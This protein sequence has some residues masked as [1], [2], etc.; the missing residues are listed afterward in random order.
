MKIKYFLVL[1]ALVLFVSACSISQF[2]KLDLDNSYYQLTFGKNV[3]LK[4]KQQATS[5]FTKNQ[6]SPSTQN[7][8]IEI[9]NYLT[10]R[11]D[12]YAG[13]ALRALETEM[14]ISM[15]IKVNKNSKFISKT[16]MSTK[17]FSS[18][19][20][21]PLAEKEMLKFVEEQLIND[22]IDKLII[23]VNLIDL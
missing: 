16:I 5:I 3:P 7:N 21:N 22:L 15:D 11:Y 9:N 12:V 18:I 10:K 23:E 17:R 19:E 20:L 14:S 4:L 8:K 1:L 6:Q 2:Q 13:D